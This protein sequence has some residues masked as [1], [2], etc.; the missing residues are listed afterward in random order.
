M[1]KRARVL[2]AGCICLFLTSCAGG[3]GDATGSGGTGG[4]QDAASGG[5]GGGAGGSGTGGSMGAGGSGTGGA[6]GA[7][8]AASG[9]AGGGL[10]G[11]AS[12]RFICP[13]GMSY[14]NPLQG[15]GAIST[16]MAPNS[17]YFAFIEGPVWIASVGGGTLFFSDNASSPT[18][19][20]FTLVPPSTTASVFIANSGSNG[21]AIDGDDQLILADQ[22]MQRIS[23]VDPT[24]GTVTAVIVPTG[25]YKPNDV[26]V[27]SDGN[28]YFTDPNSAGRG[29]YRVSP[30]GVLTGPMMQVNSPNGIELTTDENT[31][32]VGDVGNQMIYKFALQADGSVNT[33]SMGTFAHTIGTT[34]DGMALDCAGNVYAGTQQG[35]EVYT[36]AGTYI[37][38]VATGPTSNCTF[39]GADRKTLF[40]TSA[41]MLKVVTLAVPGLPD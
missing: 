22:R 24:T 7:G 14:G 20:I 18:E 38:T 15:M 19:R 30:Q 27:R 17:N 12:A 3:Q 39:G 10:H 6:S 41:S 35:V 32:L 11:G 8:G 5:S 16:I 4:G 2:T 9:G 28:I 40:A 13:T 29:F 23:R 1:M 33:A 36:S 21:L 34:V 31:L 25:N 26:I 37:G